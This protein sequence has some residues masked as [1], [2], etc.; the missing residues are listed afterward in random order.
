[1]DERVVV[2]LTEEL[3]A[4]ALRGR[5]PP[6]RALLGGLAHVRQPLAPID[7]DDISVERSLVGKPLL[8]L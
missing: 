5:Q 1:M 7:E 8:Y 6:R 4:R 2:G 3:R